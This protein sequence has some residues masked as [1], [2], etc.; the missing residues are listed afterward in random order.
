MN[1]TSKA[2]LCTLA[3]LA[4]VSCESTP[5]TPPPAP[6]AAAQNNTPGH[7]ALDASSPQLQ[8]IRTSQPELVAVPVG[9]I[10]APGKVEANANRQSHLV[11]PLAG[12]ITSV[13]VRIGDF[14]R[15]GQ[16]V[17]AIESADVD[18]AVSNLQQAQ[19]VL[20]Q[21]RS[22]L[23][24]AQ[25]DL[26]R[27][28]DLFEH[29]AIPRKELL[30]AQTVVVQAQAS[31]EQAQAV[32]E[33][34]RRRL[35]LLGITKPA[36]GQRVS[37][38]APLSG[39]V[40]DMSIVNGEFRNDLSAPV[41]TIADLSSV[42]V[43]SDVPETSIRLIH[44]GEAV[45][46]TLSA[47]PDLTFRGKVTLIGDIV[48]PQTRTVKVRVELSNADG[49]LKPEMFGNIQFAAQ[50]EQ[51]PVIPA[52]AVFSR[53]GQ[54]LVWRETARG[55]FDSVAV[56]TGAS[57]GDRVAILSGLNAGDRVVTDGVMLLTAH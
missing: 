53:D 6:A 27:E 52:S 55:T 29:G 44:T 20:T 23:A 50:M 16:P 35:Q 5:Q 43:T 51:R 48:D 45:T 34:S 26:D 1:P 15:Q 39:K 49:K 10:S 13:L 8:Q 24:K 21:T 56:T 57:I 19:A 18:A 7:V 33:Q 47:F 17:L 31:V 25:M 54:T 12:R 28:K 2:F 30:N 32:E 38:H 37:V 4:L 3:T 22:G 9:G 14:V 42:W 41:M 11:L 36:F 40:L 46:I